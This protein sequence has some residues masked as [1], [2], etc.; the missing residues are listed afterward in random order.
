MKVATLIGASLIASLTLVAGASSHSAPD[1]LAHGPVTLGS[2]RFAPYGSGWG[3]VEPRKIWNGG[4][5]SGL[6]QRIHWHHWGHH[7]AKGHGRTFI[8]KP[9][10][11]YSEAR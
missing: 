7:R 1:R 4:D 5:A 9:H 8:F 10:G 2:K 6:I 11:G 3:S